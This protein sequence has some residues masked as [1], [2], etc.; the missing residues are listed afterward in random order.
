[1]A[2]ILGLMMNSTLSSGA[3]APVVASLRHSECAVDFY[4]WP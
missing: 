4:S 3:F 2:W 1:M